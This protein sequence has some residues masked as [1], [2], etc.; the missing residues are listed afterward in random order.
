MDRAIR[1]SVHSAFVRT[2]RLTVSIHPGLTHQLVASA[3]PGYGHN[4]AMEWQSIIE[5]ARAAA[6]TQPSDYLHQAMLRVA[7]DRPYYALYHALARSNA[8]L[9]I[10]P[11]ETEGALPEWSYVY[12]D[13]GGDF[14]FELMEAD[15]SHQPEAVRRFVDVFLAAHER[16]LLAE[17]DPATIFTADQAREWLYRAEAAIT[18]FLSAQPEQRRAFALQL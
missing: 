17:E 12:T 3:Q 5:L 1:T 8:D 2:A 7:V 15:F 6:A 9:L 11:F 18:E 13:L 10:G 4:F 14:A 16:L